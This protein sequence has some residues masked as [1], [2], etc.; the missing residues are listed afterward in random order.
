[1]S[2]LPGLLLLLQTAAP[3]AEPVEA[4]TV[5]LAVADE[6]GAPIQGLTVDEVAVL[7]NG[8]AREVRSLELDRRPL[9]VAIVMDSSEPISTYFRLYVTEAVSQLVARLPEGARY[10]LWT[11][12]DRPEKIVDYTDDLAAASKALRRVA[13]RGGNTL[14]DA[15]LEASKDLRDQEGTR[16]AIIVVTGSGIGFTNS[17][18]RQVVERLEKRPLT[19]YAVQ[20]DEAREP[21]GSRSDDAGTVGGVDYDYVLAALSK[22]TGGLRETT[23]SFQGLSRALQRVVVE[24]K[25]QYRLTYASVRGAKEPKLEVRVARPEAKVR[26]GAPRP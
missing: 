20:V 12:G 13:P 14:L 19:V 4:R 2:L 5:A 22:A 18:R 1:M 15:L 6:K 9:T 23:L 10:A 8:A 11:T 17:D 21:G 16:N 3:A 7:E 24:L 26:A 25:A